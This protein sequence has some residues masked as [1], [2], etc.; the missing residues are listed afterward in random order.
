[1]I[2]IQIINRVLIEPFFPDEWSPSEFFTQAFYTYKSLNIVEGK[3]R[4]ETKTESGI[5]VSI[6]TKNGLPY[7]I[8]PH[9]QNTP[10]QTIIKG[11]H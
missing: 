3:N 11:I 8:F 10:P 6:I 2:N 9:C 7:S 4:Y 1:M 5:P